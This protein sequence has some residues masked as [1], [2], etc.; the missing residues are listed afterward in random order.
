MNTENTRAI[1]VQRVISIN[2]D[3]DP[4]SNDDATRNLAPQ[5]KCETDDSCINAHFMHK[6]G[7][8]IKEKYR[9]N[10]FCEHI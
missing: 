4:L 3:T 8:K 2:M 5:E 7:L 10:N 1:I 6:M 9:I